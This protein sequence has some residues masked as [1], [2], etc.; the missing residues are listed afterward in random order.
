MDEQQYLKKYPHT[1]RV[2]TVCNNKYS[3]KFRGRRRDGKTC[4]TECFK[5]YKKN[6][7]KYNPDVREK[8]R[9]YRRVARRKKEGHVKPV[10]SKCGYASHTLYCYMGKPRHSLKPV[11]NTYYCINCERVLALT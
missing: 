7:C 6:I 11:P 3:Y 4:S 9:A 1:K 2:C 8:K 10:C 5:K